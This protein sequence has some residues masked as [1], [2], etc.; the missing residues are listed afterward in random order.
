MQSTR[1]ETQ[2]R[3]TPGSPATFAITPTTRTVSADDDGT[4]TATFTATG[5]TSADAT[6]TVSAVSADAK[7][8]NGTITVTGTV[9][10]TVTRDYTVTVNAVNASGESATA[11]LTVSFTASDGSVVTRRS[12]GG[13]GGCDA[14]FGALALLVAAPLFIRKRK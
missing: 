4:F 14:G 2:P 11:T 7:V 5:A 10:T 6:S 8:S 1:L 12:S 3:F 13:G 9:P